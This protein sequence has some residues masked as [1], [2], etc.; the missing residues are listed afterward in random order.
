[1]DEQHYYQTAGHAVAAGVGLSLLATGAVA[2]RFKAQ[3]LRKQ[4]LKTDDWLLLPAL[5]LAVAIGMCLVYGVYREAF[6]HRL[7]PMSR[8]NPSGRALDQMSTSIKVSV[9][10]SFTLVPIISPRQRS[11]R[12]S[13]LTNSWPTP[14]LE[15]TISIL[16][17]VAM[18]CTKLSFVF[19]YRRIF[20]I[21]RTL[22]RSLRALGVLIVL[23]A[24]AVVGATL[25]CCGTMFFAIWKPV[26]EMAMC[27]FFLNVLMAFCVTGLLIDLVT[28]AI[29]IPIVWRLK[30]STTNKLVASCSFLVGAVTLALSLVRL[31]ISVG[32]VKESADPHTDFILNTTLYCYWGMVECSVSVMAA[33]IPALQIFFRRNTWQSVATRTKQLFS[34]NSRL[35]QDA[36]VLDSESPHAM[37]LGYTDQCESK[38]S[39]GPRSL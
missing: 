25:F 26:S 36:E 1:M 6:G 10:I 5:I 19:F 31:I 15:W 24:I 17:P 16:L 2:C 13:R 18:A 30:L 29:P 8:D 11:K 34:S 39:D 23:W 3:S 38:N 14:Q 7:Y 27:R 21:S 35:S 20:S 32:F 33:C 37:L 28:I 12:Q 4:P 9:M 22:D